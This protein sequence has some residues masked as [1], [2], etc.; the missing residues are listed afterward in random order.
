MA[1]TPADPSLTT[2]LGRVVLEAE[3]PAAA[4]PILRRA[5]TLAPNT[6]LPNY[7]LGLCLGR[8]GRA[9]D[10]KPFLDTA[11]RIFAD[12][13]KAQELSRQMFRDPTA[14]PE[15]R[16]ALGELLYRAGNEKLGQYWLRSAETADSKHETSH[17][18]PGRSPVVRSV[19]GA[20]GPP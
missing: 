14:G 10:A 15:Q 4:E 6:R 16:R 20:P 1:L 18:G 19:P 5:V 3:N 2:D 11:S 17:Q 7:Y 9:A 13:Q 12:A 8:L